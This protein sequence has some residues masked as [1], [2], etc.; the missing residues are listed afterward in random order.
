MMLRS[1][2]VLPNANA[3]KRVLLVKDEMSEQLYV[4]K[5]LEKNGGSS[6]SGVRE[7]IVP[8]S[9]PYMA[10]LIKFFDI[11]SFIVLLIEYVENGRLWDFLR[12][13]LLSILRCA[14]F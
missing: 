12:L 14:M 2:S 9:V 11:D 6:G 13:A 1:F 4:M 5:L 8:T 7:S 10:R 3:K